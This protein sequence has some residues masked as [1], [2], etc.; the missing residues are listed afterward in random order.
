[1]TRSGPSSANRRSGVAYGPGSDIVDFI[2]GITFEIWERRGVDLIHD[3]YAPDVEVFCLEGLISGAQAMVEGTRATLEAFPDRLLLGDNV[4]WAGDRDSG[5][6]SSHRVTSP[7]TNLGPSA[8]G[9]ATGRRVQITNI[10]DCVVENGVITREWLLRDNL[11]LVRQLGIDEVGAARRLAAGLDDRSRAWLGAEALRVGRAKVG[12]TAVARG[13]SAAA[14]TADPE[15]REPAA[16]APSGRIHADAAF[17]PEEFS[18]NLL[19]RLWDGVEAGGP[20]DLYA[21]YAVLHRSPVERF[22]G[23]EA[24]LAHYEGLKRAFGAP[25]VSLD[26]VACQPCG[27]GGWDVAA[28][29]A[30]AGEHAGAFAGA[31]ATG[32]PVFVLGA[33]HWRVVAG[34]VAAEW[35]VFDQLAVLS[36]ILG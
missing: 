1:M 6:Y 26:H 12:A 20:E 34:R 35:T 31:A 23:R 5:F 19:T 18:R 7:M 24:V 2:L 11:S 30:L 14:A 33:S 9:P 13:G 27:S 22:S 28:R 3:Y 36:Q 10:A 21:P 32:K 16:A 4:V 17:D 25:R 8:F 15:S 29:W